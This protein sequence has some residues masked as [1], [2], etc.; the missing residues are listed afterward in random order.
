MGIVFTVDSVLLSDAGAYI[1]Q[2]LGYALAWGAEWM[3]QL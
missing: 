3:A 2:E 1:A